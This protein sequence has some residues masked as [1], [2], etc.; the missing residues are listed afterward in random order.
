M[1]IIV[2]AL[3]QTHIVKVHV[4]HPVVLDEVPLFSEDELKEAASLIWSDKATEPD[5]VLLEVL[6]VIPSSCHLILLNIYTSCLRKEFFPNSGKSR[7][8]YLLTEYAGSL[9][10]HI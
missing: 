4:G 8:C 1:R 7:D 3:S 10:S 2:D 5:N 6:K 9:S